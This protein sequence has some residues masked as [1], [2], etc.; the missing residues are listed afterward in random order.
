MLRKRKNR[1]SISILIVFIILTSWA[2]V[3]HAQAEQDD[4]SPPQDVVKLIFIHHSCGENWLMDG[5]GDL[6]VTL[7]NNNYFVSDTNYGWGPNG[8]GDRTDIPNW[9]EWFVE[10]NRDT[11]MNAVYTESDANAGGWDY[12]T[13]NLSD[14]GGEN[15]I[16]MFKSCFPN[17]DLYGNPNDS[18][19]AGSDMTVANAKYIYNQLLAYFITRPDKLFVVIT[20]PPM[21]H[22]DSPENARAFNTWLVND[23]LAE[24][25]YPYSNV[26]VWDFYNVLTDPDNHHRY[27][28]GTVEYITNQGNNTLYYDSSGDDHPNEAGSQKATEEFVPLLNIFYHRWQAGNPPASAPSQPSSSESESEGGGEVESTT[29]GT[30]LQ[31]GS[32]IDDFENGPIPESDYWMGYYE[33]NVGTTITCN[34]IGSPPYSGNASLQVDFTVQSGS[35]ASCELLFYDSQDWSLG[36]GL[37]FYVRATDTGIP[38]GL[39]MYHGAA[40]NSSVVHLETNQKSVD[41]WTR[42]VFPWSE[43]ATQD[44]TVEPGQALGLAFLFD[45]G[46]GQ[47]SAGTVW[48]DDIALAG[49]GAEMVG[50]QAEAPAAAEPA[51]DEEGTVPESED[52]G[53]GG[54]LCASGPGMFLIALIGVVWMKKREVNRF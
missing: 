36:E 23:W 44:L 9:P 29:G 54:R 10:S 1:L 37:V 30:A 35:W 16:I 19:Q 50:E 7:Q 27:N 53:G 26:A 28:N 18:P 21:Q 48:I 52:Q 5:Y 38:L 6:G 20:A 42:F 49:E 34:P 22:L 2:F 31:I 17:S 33:E 25:D 43:F 15:E 4:P 13:R 12:Y 51:E 41:G 46:D 39:M 8:I 14:P 47:A 3:A 45:G 32:T 40:K 24:N 11:Y